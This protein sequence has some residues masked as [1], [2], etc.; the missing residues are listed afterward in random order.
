MRLNNGEALYVNLSQTAYYSNEYY[1]D[2]A[3]NKGRN[4]ICLIFHFHT[5]S[6]AFIWTEVNKKQYR[7]HALRSSPN[8][9][10]KESQVHIGV[11]RGGPTSFW[12]VKGEK[13]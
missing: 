1:Q 7:P 8:V 4:H 6:I 10:L 11:F 13:K 9:G 5:I 2:S 3:E 12:G